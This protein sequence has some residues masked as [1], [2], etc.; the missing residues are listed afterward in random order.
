MAP[1]R[2]RPGKLCPL[3][4]IWVPMMMSTSP[5][6]M[7]A[8]RSKQDNAILVAQAFVGVVLVLALGFHLAEPGVVGLLVIVL[9][10]A[11]NGV[12]EEHPDLGGP[13][14]VL[15]RDLVGEAHVLRLGPAGSPA[16]LTILGTGTL[17]HADFDDTDGFP[18]REW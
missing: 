17:R 16:R 1:T 7:A 4:I 3:A 5:C 12:T 2:V 9:A 10:T 8:K 6:A 14:V 13:P 15:G 11:L 18:F